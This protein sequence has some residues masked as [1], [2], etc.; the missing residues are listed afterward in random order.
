MVPPIY[1]FNILFPIVAEF[2]LISPNNFK[3]VTASFI[4]L[5]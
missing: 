5:Q 2:N 4:R 1:G 3:I